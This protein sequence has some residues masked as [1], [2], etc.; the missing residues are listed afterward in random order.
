[1]SAPGSLRFMV[2]AKPK[3]NGSPEANTMMELSDRCLFEAGKYFFITGKD[4]VQRY[5]DGNPFGPGR[6]QSTNNL[7][8]PYAT[9]EN[10]PL[11]Y[12]RQCFRWKKGERLLHIPM[13]INLCFIQRVIL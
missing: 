3:N 12:L 6:Q 13:I 11:L 5:G 7:L 2:L 9:G 8:M 4:A 10:L 1:M